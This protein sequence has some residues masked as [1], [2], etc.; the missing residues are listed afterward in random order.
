MSSHLRVVVLGTKGSWGTPPVTLFGEGQ[1][2]EAARRAALHYPATRIRAHIRVEKTVGIRRRYRVEK[3]RFIVKS[4]KAQVGGFAGS[5]YL[6]LTRR[7]N[8][9]VQAVFG[10]PFARTHRSRLAG[11]YDVDIG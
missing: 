4:P 7:S 1:V 3:L 2:S 10:S 9:Q 11:V 8:C 5:S 6:T